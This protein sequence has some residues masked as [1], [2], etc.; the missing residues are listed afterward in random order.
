MKAERDRED[1]KEGKKEIEIYESKVSFT[2][3]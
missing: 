1:R 3:F 2:T